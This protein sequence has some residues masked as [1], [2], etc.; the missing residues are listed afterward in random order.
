MSITKDEAKK[1]IFELHDGII[2]SARRSVQD[3]IKIGEIISEQRRLLAPD[4]FTPF[5]QSLPFDDNTVYRYIQLYKYVD[6]IP[7][8]GDLST[9]YKKLSEIEYQEKQTEEQRKRAL[10]AEYRRTGKKPDGWDRSLDYIIQRDK[11]AEERQ[12]QYRKEQEERREEIK[13]ER[14]Q[15]RQANNIFTEAL[16]TATNQLFEKQAE[17]EAWQKKIR[18][19]ENGKDDSFLDAIEA[20]L[21]T[22]DDDN[23]RVEACYNII[24]ICKN[25]ANEL[26][27]K[28]IK[29]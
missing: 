8:V 15:S 20:Y 3:A 13:A 18:L 7:T 26:Q 11:E 2:R 19:S 12:E 25:I 16:H 14:E 6:K 29:G 23:R 27:R 22:M 21:L 10:I 1:Q 4:E 17:K 9:A 24:K 28:N 5:I